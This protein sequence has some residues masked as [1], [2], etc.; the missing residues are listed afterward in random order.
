[1]FAFA[2][3][4]AEIV[5]EAWGAAFY[6]PAKE[7]PSE[8]ARTMI[9]PDGPR[10]LESWSAELTPYVVE[11]LDMCSLATP[12]NEVA[13]MKSAQ[14]G[15]STMLLAATGHSMASEPSDMLLV[16]PT[17]SALTDFHGEKLGPMIEHSPALKDVV[18]PQTSRSGQ[19]STTYAKK[20]GAYTL[21]L[22]IA[23]STSDLRSKTKQKVFLDEVDEYPADVNKQGDPVDMAAARQ[24]SFLDSGEWKRV[25]ISTPTIRRGS[26][27]EALFEKGDQ[28]RWHVPCPHCDGE[29]VFEFGPNFRFNRTYPYNAHYITP[30][31]GVEITGPEKNGLI[32]KGRWIATAPAPGKFP[33]YHFGGMSSPF[34]PWDTIAKR[35]VEAGEDSSKLKTFWNLTLGLPYEERLSEVSA[36]EIVA[37]TEPYPRGIVPVQ[38]ALTALAVDFNSTW[39]EWALYAFG[40]SLAGD[41]VD[42][43]L[44]EHGTEPGKPGDEALTLALNALF[45][46]RWRFAGGTE[47]I[48]DR[49]GLDSGFGT[50]EV[51][52]LVRGKPHLRALDGRPVKIGDVNKAL[53]LG[54]P[55]K[56]SAKDHLGR[57]RF[58]VDLYPVGSSDLKLWL[59][60]ALADFAHEKPRGMAIHLPR[61]IVDLTMADQLL[62]EVLVSRQRRDGRVEDVWV[63]RSGIRNEGLDLAVYARALALGIPR[64]G[65]GIEA[66][67]RAAW[68]RLIAERH[69]LDAAQ[70]DLFAGVPALAA[71]PATPPAEAPRPLPAPP[72]AAA[73]PPPRVRPTLADLARRLN[74]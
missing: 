23:T 69:G 4:F 66:L 3:S 10:K 31:C 55:T 12:E 38:A 35:F 24:E 67:T 29:F 5:A 16:Q 30:C 17:D 39:A 73:M 63:P 34:V 51:Y 13:V 74:T 53:P 27:I 71:P 9:V 14:S 18:K 48:A 70:S 49:V 45:E 42:Q 37:A 54:T 26:R 20:F 25:Y 72:T 50:Y 64:G 32:R 46:R 2:R 8:W 40:P 57:V 61:E 62:G 56:A 60:S 68:A 65:I 33:S 21:T 11:P 15:F 22:A 6:V 59:A 1:M 36:K 58:K 28:R 47:H 52:K 43:W 19:G 44:V 7:R 41:G